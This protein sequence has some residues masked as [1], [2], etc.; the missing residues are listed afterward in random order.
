MNASFLSQFNYCPI[1]WMFHN[2]LLN[3]KIDFMKDV[4]VL[5]IITVIHPM[6]NY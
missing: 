3:H 4:F 1:P 5:F 6:M 2:R